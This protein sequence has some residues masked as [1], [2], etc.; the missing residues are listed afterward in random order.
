M[1]IKEK[2]YSYNDL[3]VVPAVISKINSRS[4]CNCFYEDN[5]LPIFASCMSTVVDDSNY[6]EFEKNS[7]MPI[8]PRNINYDKRIELMNNEKWVAFSLTEFQNLFIY[9]Y[10]EREKG[11]LYNICI[12]IANG[13]MNSL[14]EICQKAKELSI[15]G[16]YKL[17][18]MT[19]NIANPETYEWICEINE[20]FTVL[21][22]NN[23]KK[24]IDYI[25]LGIGTGSQCTTS[26]NTSIHY[27]IASLID[28]C[29]I[30]KEK[31]NNAPLIV[32]DGGIRNFDHIIKALALGADY[33]MIGGL[34]AAMYES[35]SP[36]LIKSAN[37]DPL[38]GCRYIK[39]DYQYENEDKKRSDIRNRELW[40]ECYGMSTKK[41]QALIGKASKTAEGKHSLNRVK[42]TLKQ[43]TDNMISYLRSAMSYC[44]AKNLNEFIGE[45]KIIVNSPGTMIAV[46]K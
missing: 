37:E 18:I 38:E 40:K 43:W 17:V 8:I 36:L 23:P 4:E 46:N 11:K 10:T 15:I 2:G 27:P 12:D 29:N 30:I 25:R 45:P 35:A 13:H 14:Y 1:I 9:S 28:S 32:A 21:N 19:G 34:F 31:Y 20:N 22:S 33:V 26:S 6:K 5:N 39:V 44:N 16:E 42:Y 24:V 7:I 41:A 3:T